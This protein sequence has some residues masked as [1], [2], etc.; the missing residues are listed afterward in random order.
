MRKDPRTTEVRL[1]RI[2]D[3]VRRIDAT[4]ERLGSR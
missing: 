1:T 4:L 2:E 3:A